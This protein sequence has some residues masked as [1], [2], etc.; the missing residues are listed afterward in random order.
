M[1]G[2]NAVFRKYVNNF[3]VDY[4]EIP[5]TSYSDAAVRFSYRMPHLSLLS[6]TGLHPMMNRSCMRLGRAYDDVTF[7]SKALLR[8]KEQLLETSTAAEGYDWVF[9]DHRSFSSMSFRSIWETL[10]ESLAN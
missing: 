2:D 5:G 10:S 3:R 4:I 8:L 7:E 9:P 6:L 1:F